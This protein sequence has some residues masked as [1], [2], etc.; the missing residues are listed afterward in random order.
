MRIVFEDEERR[1]L[2]TQP[3]T[4]TRR[5]PDEV[6]RRYRRR[7]QQIGAARDERDLRAIRAL[8]LEKLKGDRAGQCSIRIN[9]KYRLILRFDTRDDGRVAIIIDGLDYH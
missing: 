4:R 5:W 3:G 6:T 7:I 2:A 1:R 9:R 8:N